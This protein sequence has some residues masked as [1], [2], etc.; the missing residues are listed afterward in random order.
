M[1]IIN[2]EI[3]TPEKVIL[4]EKI[5]RVSVP[6]RMGEITVL[7]DHIPLVSILAPGVIEVLTESNEIEIIALSGGFIEVLHN[8]VVILADSAERAADIDHEKA[9]EALNRA[10]ELKKQKS[11]SDDKAYLQLQALVEQEA[12]KI[13]AFNKYMKLKN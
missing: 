9:E 8:K 3:V 13:K 2:F 10:T 1:Q 7:P 12:S 4:K 6:T 5:Q 11:V